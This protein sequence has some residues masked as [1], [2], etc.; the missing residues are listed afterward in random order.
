M[1][2]PLLP[3]QLVGR[4]MGGT[5]L[6]ERRLAVAVLGVAVVDYQTYATMKHDLWSRRRFSEVRRWF[7]SDST[8]WPFS[9]LN[10]CEALDLDASAIRA[11]VRTCPRRPSL[12]VYGPGFFGRE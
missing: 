9:F 12:A 10:I 8:R 3:S 1:E 5:S 11:G 2:A 6:P 4:A 7:M